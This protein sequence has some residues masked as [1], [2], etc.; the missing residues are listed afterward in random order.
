MPTTVTIDDILRPSVVLGKI[1]RNRVQYLTCTEELGLTPKYVVNND[2][3]GTRDSNLSTPNSVELP[4]RAGLY[5]IFDRPQDGVNVVGPGAPAELVAPQVVGQVAYRVARFHPAMLFKYDEMN[6]RRSIG[7][8]ANVLDKGGATYVSNQANTLGLRTLNSLEIMTLGMMRDSLYLEPTGAPDA[9][10]L[11]FTAG[12][13]PIRINFQMPAGNKLKLDMLGSGDIVATS[14]DNL[15]A[16]ILADLHAISAAFVK[17]CGRPLR[18][19]MVNSKGWMNII[20]NTEVRTAAG[21]ATSPYNS[22]EVNEEKMADGIRRATAKAT[23]KTLPGV[24]FIINDEWITVAG[25]AVQKIPDA[26]A[27]FCTDTNDVF[28]LGYYSEQIAEQPGQPPMFKDAF[29][30]WWEHKSDPSGV[31]LYY[32]MNCIPMNLVPNASAWGTVV[33]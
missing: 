33:Y 20:N 26:N 10:K 21:T 24:E 16:P 23:L 5:D 18:K 29:S 27:F 2:E 6:Q 30:T 11:S 31:K 8:A 28:K 17:L 14:W 19:V 13:N 32:L 15:A 22:Y 9:Y 25:T 12:T 7:Q 4:A 3:D 1:S